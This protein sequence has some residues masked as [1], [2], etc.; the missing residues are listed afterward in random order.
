MVAFCVSWDAK[1]KELMII[2]NAGRLTFFVSTVISHSLLAIISITLVYVLAIVFSEGL[3]LGVIYVAYALLTIAAVIIG[4]L[5]G[6]VLSSSINAVITAFIL[7]CLLAYVGITAPQLTSSFWIVLINQLNVVAAFGNIIEGAQYQEL[8]GIP[9]SFSTTF[10]YSD[11]VSP[12]MSILFMAFD[13]I[14]YF[15]IVVIYDSIEWAGY[16]VEMA[17]M[18]RKTNLEQLESQSERKSWHQFE[19][20]RPEPPDVDTDG[21]SK[22][23]DASGALLVYRFEIRAYAGEVSVILGHSGC[24]KSTIL[25]MICGSVEPTRGAVRVCNKN[26]FHFTSYCRSKLGYCPQ[27]NLLYKALTVED[28]LWLFY[29]IKRIDKAGTGKKA[30]GWKKE[31]SVLCGCLE[32][33]EA[34]Q[35]QTSSLSQS[36]MR[37]LC[38]AI[39]FIGGSRVVLL[40]EPTNGMDYKSKNNL[41]DLILKH[42]E[43]RAVLLTTESM[44]DAEEMGQQLYVMYNG[45]TI[46]SGDIQ[47]VKGSFG[48]GY[49]LHITMDEKDLDRTSKRLQDGITAS[50]AGS[51]VR[52]KK[53]KEMEIE[54]PKLQERLF[55]KMLKTLEEEK[56]AGYVRDFQLIYGNIEE[57]FQK[58]IMH[59][60]KLFSYMEKSSSH[61]PPCTTASIAEK[62]SYASAPP[63]RF[64]VFNSN[65]DPLL[66]NTMTRFISNYKHIKVEVINSSDIAAD[67]PTDWPFVLGAMHITGLKRDTSNT[68]VVEYLFPKYLANSHLMMIHAI[69]SSYSNRE[70]IFDTDMVLVSTGHTHERDKTAAFILNLALIL[71]TSSFAIAPGE[72]VQS[73]FKRQ[74]LMTGTPRRL[75]WLMMIIFDSFVAALVCLVMSFVLQLVYMSVSWAFRGLM[76]LYCVI[77]LPLA[78]L[79]S[80]VLKSS[81]YAYLVLVIFQCVALVLTV[82]VHTAIQGVLSWF[83]FIFPS[84]LLASETLKEMEKK[85]FL[86]I[87]RLATIIAFLV[88]GVVYLVILCLIELK[89]GRLIAKKLA[90]GG[91][92]NLIKHRGPNICLKNISFGVDKNTRFGLVGESGA[93]KTVLFDIVTGEDFPTSG[94]AILSGVSTQDLSRVGCSSQQDGLC[95]HLTCRQNIM[96]ILALLGYSGIAELTKLLIE[97]IGVKWCQHKLVAHCSKSQRRRIS[98]GLA[99][100]TKSRI[101]ALDE[102]TRGVDPATRRHIWQLITTTQLEERMIFFTSSTIEECEKISDRYGILHQG[103]LAAIGPVETMSMRHTKLYIL[104]LELVDKNSRGRVE[105]AVQSAFPSAVKEA[106]PEGKTEILRWRIPIDGKN[107]LSAM[108]E[109]MK[110]VTSGLPVSNPTL[111]QCSYEIALT[112]AATELEAKPKGAPIDAL[113]VMI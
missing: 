85:N 62:V 34:L 89:I 35:K 32:L 28:H 113:S 8:R 81:A 83:L 26:V 29:N 102:P 92:E 52:T 59:V 54:L 91:P 50:V 10:A 11:Y 53:G 3:P 23:D 96:I 79:L 36:E 51:K 30:A 104:E 93:G 61:H 22:V 21:V 48:G 64:I 33:D 107:R 13:I 5:C 56:Q 4:I 86:D 84:T 39:A 43:N 101:I 15:A 17:T 111:S 40:D 60:P 47:F 90:G 1:M 112:L 97:T 106:T 41:R 69:M 70:D 82:T 42:K 16:F 76:L 12:G 78:Y 14:L 55:P 71:L 108:F 77:N 95:Y 49:M 100:V 65:G 88:H 18:F 44:E 109:R 24:G 87:S 58:Q 27:D 72:E 31:A 57:T 73:F 19:N 99:L 110:N 2:M 9:L 38:V 6:T 45:R 103:R 63:G 74:Q 66:A 80:C 46:C 67:W 7:W 98:I 20:V 94:Q 105:T 75:Y 37:K 68:G 25:K